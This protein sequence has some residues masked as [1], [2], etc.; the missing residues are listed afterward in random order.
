MN[1]SERRRIRRMQIENEKRERRE[2]TGSN[3]KKAIGATVGVGAVY[4][5][6]K[7]RDELTDIAQIAT[8]RAAEEIGRRTGNKDFQR[9]VQE[10]KNVMEAVSK[11][12]NQERGGALD[13]FTNLAKNIR[14]GKTEDAIRRRTELLNR[15]LT[16]SIRQN[17]VPSDVRDSMREMRG[18]NSDVYNKAVLRN[19]ENVLDDDKFKDV[20]GG[21]KEE[22][23]AI[24]RDSTKKRNENLFRYSDARDSD[25]VDE[26]IISKLR[27]FNQNSERTIDLNFKDDNDILETAKSFDEA[28]RETKRVTRE[29]R[30]SFET[31]YLNKR[32]QSHRK[33]DGI[34]DNIYAQ[35]KLAEEAIRFRSIQEKGS[36]PIRGARKG[37][38]ER[39]WQPLTM[40]DA[41]E[42]FA[43]RDGRLFLDR[44]A[45][46][47][48][49]ID[50]LFSPE[51]KAQGGLADRFRKSGR[52]L[53]VSD[54][55]IDSTVFSQD[56]YINSQTNEILNIGSTEKL[57]EDTL[58]FLQ[59]NFQVPVIGVNPI[60][61]L[62]RTHKR[63]QSGLPGSA[64]YRAGDVSA[65][66]EDTL[67]MVQDLHSRN[68]NSTGVLA[69]DYVHIGDKIY[70]G[71][72][73][74]NIFSSESGSVY[75]SFINQLDENLVAEGYQIL[76]TRRGSARDFA[77]VRS[78][79]QTSVG[80]PNV[81]QRFFA[82][83]TGQETIL[84]D[85]KQTLNNFEDANFGQ[86]QVAAILRDYHLEDYDQAT[87]RIQDV[88][89]KLERTATPLSKETASEVH[90]ILANAISSNTL[91]PELTSE[92]FETQE[93][94]M[95]AA[96][97]IGSIKTT[98]LPEEVGRRTLY[99]LRDE[100]KRNYEFAKENP[101]DF[102]SRKTYL[103]DNNLFEND[104]T[105][106]TG[107]DKPRVFTGEDR[108]RGLIE[109]YGVLSAE[110]RGISFEDEI[111]GSLLKNKDSILEELSQLTTST[112]VQFFGKRLS[113]VS[114]LKERVGL[115]EE[116]N[117][118]FHDNDKYMSLLQTMGRVEPFGSK[119]I[120]TAYES[121]TGTN[122]MP[123]K[124][125]RG[126]LR[127]I[128]ETYNQMSE[129]E[130]VGLD[131]VIELLGDAVNPLTGHKE[132][133][134][135]SITPWRMLNNL[136]R[137][138]EKYGL[139]LPS[140]MRQSPAG[141]IG[142][143]SVN[144]LLKPIMA[145]QT[146]KSLD[147][148]FLQGAG[149]RQAV[150]GYANMHTS[151][152]GVR[153]RLGLTRLSKDL[154]TY[155]PGMEHLR[156]SPIG[157]AARGLSFGLLGDDRSQEEVVD[158]YQSGEDPIRK[159]RWWELGSTT[160]W[161]G[162]RIEYY[163]PNL[164]RRVMSDYEYTDTMY[165][166]RSEYWSNH[167]MPN[168]Y[169]PLAPVNHFLLRPY[170]Y[171]EKH[172]DSRPYAVTG[173]FPVLQG[174]PIIGP[175]V[176]GVVSSVL[177]P[178]Q[179]HPGLRK[180]HRQYLRAENER[181]ISAY[182]GV[183]APGLL[184]ITPKGK[185]NLTTNAP[186]VNIIDPE[187]G[188][189][190][191]EALMTND[192]RFSAEREGIG[193][194]VGI[195]GQVQGVQTQ[196]TVRDLA[197]NQIA[198]YNSALAGVP[199]GGR[200]FSPGTVHNQVNPY[201]IN[202]RED[203]FQA[204]GLRDFKSMGIHAADQLQDMGGMFGFVSANMA[205]LTTSDD[206]MRLEDSS[207]FGNWNERFWDMNLGGFDGV[208]GDVSEIM[209]RFIGG[210]RRNNYYNPL[211]NQMPSWMPSSNYF[212]DFSR[213]DPYKKIPYGEIRL[214]G[215]AYEQ[216]FSV[217]KDQFGNY[218]AFDRYRILAD[219]APF[220]D[221]YRL[222]KSEVA[223]LNQNGM[224]D[225]RKQAEYRQIRE[226]V[227]KKSKKHR[228]YPK[229]FTNASINRETVTITKVIDQN[230]FLT[231]EYGNNPI[232]LAGVSIRA[233]DEENVNLMRSIIR[234]GQ[235]I[236]VGLD[237][238]PMNRVRDDMMD[239]M[240][241]VVYA[242]GGVRSFGHSLRGGQ[243]VNQFLSNQST[244]DGGNITIRD[245]G[246]AV[247][248]AALH[249]EG[250]ITVG[251]TMEWVA[252]D[253]LPNVPFLN[254]FADKFYPIRTPVKEYERLTYSKGFRSWQRPVQDWI[255]PMFDTA[256]NMN[257]FL[258]AARGAGI[259]SMM[260]RN[261]Q[262][263]PL[264]AHV[265]A[266]IY[267]TLAGIRSINELT[268]RLVGNDE[269]WKPARRRQ[270]EEVDEYFDRIQYIKYK[271]LYEQAK[272]LAKKE[273]GIDLDEYLRLTEEEG[274]SNT[275]YQGYLEDRKKWINIAGKSSGSVTVKDF[276]KA[277][278]KQINEQLKEIDDRRPNQM[279]GSYTALA[280]R[281]K[282]EYESTLYGAKDT[283]DYM[284][285]YRAMPKRDKEF[286]TAF[287]KA[288]PK[289]RQEILRL[290]P[291]NQRNIYR[292]QWGLDIDEDD[293]VSNEEF[294]SEYKLPGENWEGWRPETSLEN[295]QIK[296]MQNEGMDL[297]E[298]NYWDEHVDRAKMSPEQAIPIQRVSPMPLAGQI[299][300][301]RLK[302]ALEGAGLRN[303]RIGMRTSAS[304]V[305]HFNTQLT[306]NK[307]REEEIEE[308][309]RE[310]MN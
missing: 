235:K 32:L 255:I 201:R 56:L 42:R 132:V 230:T 266:S 282:E 293:D 296:V 25:E 5:G 236:Q 88:A 168:I 206:R 287:Q 210:R 108:L 170:H 209:R 13:T 73:I 97:W 71:N 174:I 136:N 304:D 129:G 39:G 223:L 6:F 175:A 105:N 96:R 72:I 233:D 62:Q 78:R 46:E 16:E 300:Q 99:D 125:H 65:F 200:V 7:Y 292:K 3:I 50:A 69:K 222:A 95:E 38:Q 27:E 213:G 217:Q 164:Y 49:T 167:W 169:N 110:Q 106:V 181:L 138:V 34:R 291:K 202:A 179:E 155:V 154:T 19:L 107:S 102:F 247:A 225:E 80:D 89:S 109:S 265:G 67:E 294:F 163:R 220:S 58:D 10:T 268:N 52:L 147:D 183:N 57:F 196:V 228:F 197:R 77:D 116:W 79:R 254:I 267:G 115:A 41:R 226:Q 54:D 280:L 256:T 1:R 310:Y 231:K 270:Q 288:S 55:I 142:N 133:T 120:E 176:D 262:N 171:E 253:L 63:Q 31:D 303:V 104:F 185:V 76:N 20:L 98:D 44:D 307:N 124:K 40:A 273:E 243:N 33:V 18:R 24:A 215:E 229:Q 298:A 177:K 218:S 297:T 182:T 43:E 81:L 22:L 186:E 227:S 37:L 86:N 143:M 100:I 141:I 8:S 212:I 29:Q 94:L 21:R 207:R 162:G 191:E 60:D 286:F 126:I 257:P 242:P 101:E 272:E 59:D 285:I 290:V 277:Q 263:R 139:G 4:A 158:Y 140:D 180:A 281:Y 130:G 199:Q 144:R 11:T 36:Q 194:G 84:S 244:E 259:F 135:G 187:T 299:N 70:D 260:S 224:L 148:F 92:M 237:A 309:L 166:S 118:Y 178:S 35:E 203:V 278:I 305:A 93:G 232:K 308:G 23:I 234:P 103:F 66:T 245:D 113:N 251:K 61:L 153:D 306:I 9:K 74:E 173:G 241:A 149:R 274:Q 127:G 111:Q 250:Q 208:G 261:P 131:P 91:N 30:D 198:Q 117:D 219:T 121:V 258:A 193:Q 123:I 12:Y 47:G 2:R 146:I 82:L 85:L 271:G 205:G 28:I 249:S 289:E 275:N 211:P 279:I 156:G 189:I 145:Y 264:A 134:S 128:N 87:R 53:G 301:A 119:G 184:S 214:P 238:D 159:G 151:M 64:I 68:E 192:I 195:S 14:P 221:E 51:Y 17:S 172:R 240:R 160:P 26:V 165:G 252:H 90:D 248:T 246:S 137:R 216:V 188:M 114:T 157:M 204:T 295:I 152:A 15:S 122:Y 45:S 150:Q 269:K 48:Q 276:A 112:E 239:T 284:K 83:D 302:K 161:I 283:Y 190:D 75:D